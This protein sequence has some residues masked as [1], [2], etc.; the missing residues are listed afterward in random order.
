MYDPSIAENAKNPTAAEAKRLWAE[1]EEAAGRPEAVKR[2]SDASRCRRFYRGDQWSEYRGAPL[3]R[4]VFNVLR[5]TV[6]YQVGALS[7]G[8]YSLESESG[9]RI[10]GAGDMLPDI[11]CDAA[12]T[13]MGAAYL[14]K[15]KGTVRF[16]AVDPLS[17]VCAEPDIADID[18]Q[19][20]VFLVFRRPAD[21]LRAMALRAGYP[22]AGI[23]PDGDGSCLATSV[24]RMRRDGGSVRFTE[25]TRGAVIRRGSCGAKRYPLSLM[26]WPCGRAGFYGF[27]PASPLIGNQ[28]CLNLG[29]A[30]MLKHMS[31]TAFSKIL[32]DRSLIPEWSNEVGEAIGVIG[33][34][35]VTRAAAAV[36]VG[37]MQDGM[38]GML[39]KAAE[40]TKELSGATETALGE[41]SADNVSAILAMRE[42]SEVSLRP[43]RRSLIS[44]LER[45]GGLWLEM[46]GAGGSVRC[47]AASADPG[48]SAAELKRLYERGDLSAEDYV[49]L[50]PDGVIGD[51]EKVRE[52]V[53]RVSDGNDRPRQAG[54]EI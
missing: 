11:I 33:G 18:S 6:D 5:R 47:S 23:E 41:G 38:F 25:F 53:R 15:E 10:P 21:E 1:Y 22:S 12:L 54:K 43:A 7:G 3:P 34:G 48:A 24:T 20:S 19:P 17:V 4:P 46:S 36:G 27:S 42:A 13:G 44:A 52:S 45:F 31:D 51:R 9:S 37:Q 29:W 28:K 30:M 35:D 49:S 26:R 39:D 32:Y 14:W 50:L 40:Q 2:A 16:G 8:G